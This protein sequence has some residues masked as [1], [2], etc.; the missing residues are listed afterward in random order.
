MVVL[1]TDAQS[2][3]L[4]LKQKN[5]MQTKKQQ[6]MV[7]THQ[8]CP[9]IVT[10]AAREGTIIGVHAAGSQSSEHIIVSSSH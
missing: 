5:S 4:V 1:A 10:C 3:Q 9:P 7:I 2:V 6:H 8:Q